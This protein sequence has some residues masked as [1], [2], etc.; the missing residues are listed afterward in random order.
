M[1]VTFMV[2]G[3][4]NLRARFDAGMLKSKASPWLRD[5]ES[6][7]LIAASNSGEYERKPTP[8]ASSGVSLEYIFKLL[9]HSSRALSKKGAST[10]EFVSDVVLSL[11]S[12]KNNSRS[13]WGCQ[14][15][16]C[17]AN[18]TFH[19]LACILFLP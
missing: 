11:T 19:F 5:A 18:S 3:G 2:V 7:G 9:A 14:E 17:C 6:I 15:R 8:T 16:R 13:A 1:G 12:K 4:L 10:A